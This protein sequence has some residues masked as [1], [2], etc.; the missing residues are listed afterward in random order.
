MEYIDICLMVD[1]DG[2]PRI[3]IAPAWKVDDGDHVGVQ[4]D[5]GTLHKCTVTKTHTVK[6]DDADY[7]FIA[8]CF[9]DDPARLRIVEKYYAEPLSWD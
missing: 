2:G 9:G 3:G 4:I 6:Q 8:A 5:D 7:R 1:E